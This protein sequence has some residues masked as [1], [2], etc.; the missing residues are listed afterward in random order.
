MKKAGDDELK[1]VVNV[2][3]KKQMVQ[4]GKD[5]PWEAAVEDYIFSCEEFNDLNVEVVSI[6]NNVLAMEEVELV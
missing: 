1:N 3:E 6:G 2:Q 4:D 5:M